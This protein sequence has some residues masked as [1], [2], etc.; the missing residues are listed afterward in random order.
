MTA[1]VW[2]NDVPAAVLRRS[3]GA[4][5]FSYLDDYLISG[6][7]AIATSLPTTVGEIVTPAGALPPFFA[8]LLP[9]GRRLSALKRAVKTSADNELAL[10][11]AV[12]SNTVGNVAV[13]P[14]GQ[15]PNQQQESI[16]L[17]AESVR[18]AEI[19]NMGGIPDPFAIP[20]VQEKASARAIAL[21]VGASG[22]LKV[23]PPEFPRLV[24]NEFAMLE[25]YASM[26]IAKKKVEAAHIVHDAED[27]SGLLVERFDGQFPHKLG[28]E[29]ASQLLGIYPAD[30]YGVSFED[31]VRA[32]LDVVP[33]KAVALRDLAVQ[34]AFAWLTG[35]GD[36]HA[37]NISVIHTGK[38]FELSPVYDIPS[39]LPYGDTTL[40]LTV[41]GRKDGLSRKKFTGVFTDLGLPEKV[42]EQVA[43]EVLKHTADVSDI[44]VEVCQLDGRRERD[45]RRVLNYRRS[46][47]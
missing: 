2:I 25:K 18:F 5:V 36:L 11:L 43:D 30:K 28:V 9:E 47:W 37:K 42:I 13:L 15:Q 35:N 32:V 16:D 23:S 46:M 38:G 3:K 10:L 45:V 41:G 27:R 40:A 39:T 26:R 21:P 44:L 19:L 20:G 6:A 14:E 7:P 24:E 17:E 12:G 33:T 4:T 31:V 34:L 22:I 8:G 29:D 1:I